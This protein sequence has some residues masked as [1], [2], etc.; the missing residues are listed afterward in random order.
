MYIERT[1]TQ[2]ALGIERL[3]GGNRAL[4]YANERTEQSEREGQQATI[5]IY[6]VYEISD[7]RTPAS[8]KNAVATDAHPLGDETKILRKA[9]ASI[10]QKLN[11][12]DDPSFAEFRNYN[13]F[14]Q[15]L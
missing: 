1:E 8:I 6:D 3:T 10:L 4:L 2:H 12:Y 7:S 14:L 11:I 5:Y 9:I 13:E 15:S